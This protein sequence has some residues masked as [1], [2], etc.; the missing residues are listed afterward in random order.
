MLFFVVT[1]GFV[2]FL[3]FLSQPCG[4]KKDNSNNSF[5][6]LIYDKMFSKLL[7]INRVKLTKKLSSKNQ[8][9]FNL[10]YNLS[11]KK[12]YALGITFFNIFNRVFNQTAHL[13]TF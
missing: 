10:T 11:T 13:S 6:T 7:T 5:N 2:F 3:Y 12:N 9:T 4:N 8:P 1:S